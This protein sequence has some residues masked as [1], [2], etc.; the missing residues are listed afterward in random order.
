MPP[1]L[2][3]AVLVATATLLWTACSGDDAGPPATTLT[4]RPPVACP[5]P[6]SSL[7][8]ARI[9]GGFEVDYLADR[10]SLATGDF[11]DDGITDLL[12]GAPLADGPQDTR[13]NTGEAHV[14][15][16]SESLPPISDTGDGLDVTIYGQ[17]EQNNFG[18]S[19]AAG[20][21]NGDGVDDIVAGARFA[22]YG[23]RGQVGQTYVVFG[24]RDLGGAIDL[25]QGGEDVRITGVDAGDFSGLIVHAADL[26]GDEID[27]V[28]IGAPAG[29]GPAN[30]RPRA[31]EVYVIP[32][33]QALPPEI[34]LAA[35]P[36]FFTVYGA[37]T[38]DFIPGRVAA[39]D[40][41]DDGRSDLII[42]APL[43]TP[44]GDADLVAAGAVYAVSAPPDGGSVDLAADHAT[45][46]GLGAG[47]RD[48]LGHSLATA[49]FDDDGIPDIIAGARDRDGAGD[50]APNAGEIVAFLGS[51]DLPEMV[52]LANDE[53][54]VRIAGHVP[55]GS[56][57][58]SLAV[59]D[60]NGDGNPDILAGAPL[61]NGCDDSLQQSGT[62][63]AID[64]ETLEKS[65]DLS[66]PATIM[67]TFHGE[68]DGDEAG[69]SL[70]TGD[71]NHDAIDDIIIGALLADGPDDSR[72]DAGEI[73]VIPG[74]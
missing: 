65:I 12:A 34:D 15:F 62:V 11:N 35:T 42:G 56:L 27:D 18:L 44:N 4:Q 5:A 43:A 55:G 7:A 40:I 17:E 29:A 24:R 61:T 3:A 52:D 16:G 50:A 57:G 14:L 69:F 60:L 63:Y 22:S 26:T 48:G 30:D 33:S 8:S 59:G 39:A 21:V 10:Y 47:Q 2:S 46:T 58:F 38:D 67:R 13:L 74:E 71:L 41:N 6:L 20:D 45:F 37:T 9:Q 73:F 49:D 28:I 54:D 32:G 51:A 72:S 1:W 25:A 36:P 53:P 68:G 19:V 23:D 70:A 66:D 31:G 64:G